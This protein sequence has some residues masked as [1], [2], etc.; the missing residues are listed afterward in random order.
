MFQILTQLLELNTHVPKAYVDILPAVLSP[1]LYDMHGNIPALCA[2]IR[3]YLKKK[4]DVVLAK[5]PAVAAIFNKILFI[6]RMVPLV[7]P[8]LP[9]LTAV[10]SVTAA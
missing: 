3:S 8:S 6:R 2:L 4:S 10:S 9:S 1:A 7:C 5:L